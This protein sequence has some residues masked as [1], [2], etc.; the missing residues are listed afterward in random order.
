MLSCSVVSESFATPWTITTR[1]LYPWNPPGKNL[2]EWI[3]IPLFR[4]SSRL[5]D[6]TQ[7]SCIV[8]ILDHLSH[9]GSPKRHTC[10]AQ[11]EL[12]YFCY[13]I[14]STEML[15]T[16]VLEVLDIAITERNKRNP[17]GKIRSKTITAYR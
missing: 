12:N 8:D 15:P 5:K 3:V 11:T 10:S 14:S 1:L 7:I 13:I 17:N 2:L 16:I 6:R 9:K 4:G